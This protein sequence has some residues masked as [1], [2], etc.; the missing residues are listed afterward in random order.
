[1]AIRKLIRRIMARRTQLTLLSVAAA[2]C[3]LATVILTTQVFLKLDEYRTAHSDNIQWSVA[4]LEVEHARY[5]HAIER[6]TPTDPATLADLRMRF[7]IFY[8]RVFTLSSAETYQE[9]L[10]SN[11]AQ[12]LVATLRDGADRQADLIDGP[13]SSVFRRRDELLAMADDLVQTTQRLSSV[14]IAYDVNRRETQRT[15][16]A[17]KLVQMIALSLVLLATLSALLALFWQLYIR[18]RRRAMQNRNT[19]NRL[20]TIINTSQ[21]AIIVMNPSGAVLEG[22]RIAKT[23]FGLPHDGKNRPDISEILFKADANGTLNP[24]T[25]EMLIRSCANGP[26]LCTKL[27]ARDNSGRIFPVEMS[28][29]LASRSGDN[30]CVCFLRDIS[31]RVATEA[32]MRAARDK[33][34]AGERAKARFL[35]M[36]S[37]EMRTPL[38]GILGALDLLDETQLSPEQARYTQI[39]QSSGQ[40]VLNQI[41]DALEVTQAEGEPLSLVSDH[42]DLD[43]LLTELLQGQQAQALAHGNTV[44]LIR[45]TVPLGSVTGDPNRLHQV[46]LNL[47]SNAI[48]FTRGGLITIEV[49]RL[50]PVEAP[51][52]E[53]EFQISDTGMGIDERDLS[54]IFEDF[55]RLDDNGGAEGTGL[56]LGIAKHLVTLMGGEIGAESERHEG[57]LFWVRLPLPRANDSDDIADAAR[58]HQIPARELDILVVEDNDSSRFVLHEML[59]KDGHQVVLATD[60]HEGVT[61]AGKRRFDLILM[62]INMPGL[63]GI[64]ATRQIRT[65]DGP[66]RDSRIVALTA[67]FQPELNERFRGVQ[68]DAICTKPLRRAA[69]RDILA[70]GPVRE[71]P[72]PGPA[73]VDT[74]VLDQLYAVLP[75]KNLTRVLDAFVAEGQGI[76]D[77]LDAAKVVPGQELAAELHQFAG[78]AATFGAVALQSALFRA[79]IAARSDDTEALRRVL[80]TLPD[81]WRDTLSQIDSRRAA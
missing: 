22:N 64:E 74:Q 17:N 41:N 9:A 50:G 2:L 36:I 62:D 12:E 58:L 35:G 76:V 47:L 69:L 26:N 25:G 10:S 33:A 68:I 40:L 57:S 72:R 45:S 20:A 37:H 3:L 80:A 11:R 42:F 7:D 81:L 65:G 53:V 19:L 8:S 63:D 75:V 70:G 6:L 32:E 51:S 24:V 29:N 43:G 49:T 30:V 34:L 21:D 66:S 13:E 61:E 18:Y 71:A 78:S 67:H 73:S 4:K 60:G 59:R 1:M 46:L 39:M 44:E 16:L 23:I 79:E 48:K 56:G 38:N 77:R 28:A 55:V 31:Q 52:D 15:V 5:L 27:S 14:G 54:R